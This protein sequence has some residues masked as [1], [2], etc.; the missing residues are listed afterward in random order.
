MIDPLEDTESIIIDI[1]K[2]L[3]KKINLMHCDFSA[4]L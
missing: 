3:L 1:F 2:Y 4:G